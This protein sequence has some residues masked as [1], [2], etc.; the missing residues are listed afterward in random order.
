MV[1]GPVPAIVGIEAEVGLV[2]GVKAPAT[3]TLEAVGAVQPAGMVTSMDPPDWLVPPAGLV[4]VKVMPLVMATPA[5]T[6]LG[7][8]EAVMVPKPSLTAKAGTVAVANSMS[9]RPIEAASRV[10][11]NLDLRNGLFM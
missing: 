5:V 9:V 10:T 6:V 7:L 1:Q 8:E 11:V 3:L 4:N 2:Q